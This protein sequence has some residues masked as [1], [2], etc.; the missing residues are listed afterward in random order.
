MNRDT[1]QMIK[2]LP[3]R[4]PRLDRAFSVEDIREL[5]RKRLPRSPFD[6][7]DGAAEDEVTMRAN[8]DAFEQVT[9][10]PRTLVDVETRDLSTTVLGTD[11]SIPLVLGPTGTPALS[12]PDA[13]FAAARAAAKTGTAFV[14]STG[15]SHPLDE[16]AKVATGPL[17]FQLYTSTDP[18]LTDYFI[19]S[20]KAS[21]CTAM[22][23]TVDCPIGGPRERD[24]R[25]GHTAPPRITR[26]SL[27]DG[28]RHP[29]RLG[30]WIRDLQRGPGMRLGTIGGYGQGDS[31]GW[32]TSVFNP[33]LTWDEVPKIRERWQG[34]L[35]IKGIMS[36]ADA[37]R[38]ADM[39]VD[40]IVVSNHGGRQLDGLPSTLEVLPR[41]ADAV[42]GTGL[43]ILIDGGVRRGGDIAR[44]R[45]LGATACLIARP[46]VWGMAA[47]GEDG[48]S[49]VVE[50]LRGEL[51]RA[52]ALLGVR[53]ISEVSSD[54]VR[55]PRDW[56]P[57]GLAAP[58]SFA[59]GV[60]IMQTMQTERQGLGLRLDD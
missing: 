2:A 12:H 9:F 25:N 15:S 17:W 45:A 49:R 33:R 58:V 14:V 7:I 30:R 4:P 24:L 6:F 54:F 22:L 46:W 13:E 55:V 23:L 29:L 39:E 31:I 57:R 35:A 26:N 8:R 42:E 41:I 18:G 20:A 37:R 52:L 21:G 32:I 5:A 56:L 36:A 16:I 19:D 11:V 43:Q 60:E 3:R 1:W 59:S 51:D 47:G 10:V 44:A 53:S 50:I 28:A 27:V 38:A 40:G 34:P 48:I